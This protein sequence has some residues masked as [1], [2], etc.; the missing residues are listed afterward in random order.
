[1]NTNTIGGRF[2]QLNAV[3]DRRLEAKIKE[4]EKEKRSQ[5]RL[6]LL[7]C[8]RQPKTVSWQKRIK[9]NIICTNIEKG[10]RQGLRDRKLKPVLK[11]PLGPTIDVTAYIIKRRK[12]RIPEGVETDRGTGERGDTHFEE[13]YGVEAVDNLFSEPIVMKG[14]TLEYRN[15]DDCHANARE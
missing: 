8:F 11:S 3:H 15:H 6:R 12:F 10:F 7:I 5:K 4:L 14:F 9:T 1:M 13:W 2:K